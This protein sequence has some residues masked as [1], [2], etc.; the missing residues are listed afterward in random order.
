MW[1]E[2]K[3]A[4]KDEGA[5]LK[6]TVTPIPAIVLDNVVGLGLDPKVERDEDDAANPAVA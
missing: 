5:T 4:I 1:R 3:H 6:E 2:F